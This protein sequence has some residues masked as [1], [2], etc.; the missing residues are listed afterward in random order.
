VT[1]SK[2][3]YLVN[4]QSYIVGAILKGT[5]DVWDSDVLS[6]Y[7]TL[8]VNFIEVLPDD[9]LNDAAFT[10]GLLPKLPSDLFY[11]LSVVSDSS[12]AYS[13]AV[14][15]FAAVLGMLCIMF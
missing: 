12:H 15:L 6:Y 5:P 14:S 10:S 13:L 8:T 4:P 9:L 2:L 7:H 3:G 1:Y 11:P